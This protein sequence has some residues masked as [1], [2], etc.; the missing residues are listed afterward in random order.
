MG[1]RGISQPKWHAAI[2][3]VVVVVVVVIVFVAVFFVVAIMNCMFTHYM[4]CTCACWPPR[5]DLGSVSSCNKRQ[6]AC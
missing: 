4:I 6:M 5:I 1:L 3:A 2:V